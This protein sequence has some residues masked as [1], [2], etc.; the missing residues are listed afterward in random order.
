MNSLFLGLLVAG[1]VLVIGVLLYN[2]RQERRARRR[3]EAAFTAPAS[4]G[5]DRAEPTLR[6]DD[7]DAGRGQSVA[8]EQTPEEPV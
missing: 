4:A 2:L 3:V 5:E 8:I 6:G 1:V 7:S